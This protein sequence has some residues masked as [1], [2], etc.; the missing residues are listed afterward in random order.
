MRAI[1]CWRWRRRLT[2]YVDGEL[3]LGERGDLE[4][5]LGVC[6]D[7]QRRVRIELAVRHELRARTTRAGPMTW[8]PRPDFSS[9][10]AMPRWYLAPAALAVGAMAVAYWAGVAG[11]PVPMHAVGVVSDSLCNGVHHPLETPNVAPSACVQGCIRKGASYVIVAGNR[12]YTVRNQDFGE[13]VAA[14]GRT[15]EV[16]GTARGSELTLVSVAPVR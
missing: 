3:P 2:S 15:V 8:L 5:H 12:I 11:G 6:R 1:T 7:C 9:A 4:R 13:L 10:P 16:S 14:A